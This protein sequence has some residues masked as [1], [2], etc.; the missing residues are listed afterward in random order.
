MT[1]LLHTRLNNNGIYLIIFNYY[2]Y[3]AELKLIAVPA[4]LLG[5]LY[6]KESRRFV[7]IKLFE[8]YSELHS[9]L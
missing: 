2:Y 3:F 4:D 7:F 6:N 5:F 9:R 8:Q 1:L